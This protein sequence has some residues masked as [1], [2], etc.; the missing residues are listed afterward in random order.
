MIDVLY[1][2]WRYLAYP[3]D[4]FWTEEGFRFSW[5]VMLVVITMIPKH[6]PFQLL[7]ELVE[8]AVAKR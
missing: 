4:L 5:R 3:G 8:V 1:L 7:V 6:V 2:A